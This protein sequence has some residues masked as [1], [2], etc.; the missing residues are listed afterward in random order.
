LPAITP[1]PF[2]VPSALLSHI[3]DDQATRVKT[4]SS[5]SL[6]FDRAIDLDRLNDAFSI[7]PEITGLWTLEGNTATFTPD[8]T[9]FAANTQ[10]TVTIRPTATSTAG[11]LLMQEPYQFSFTTADR[12]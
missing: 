5:L 2:T 1:F 10:Y 6:T 4:S 8:D 7:T 9:F 3:P 11:D 12:E